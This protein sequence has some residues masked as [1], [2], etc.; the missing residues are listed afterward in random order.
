M[1]SVSSAA[2]ERLPAR[3]PTPPKDTTTAVNEAL[4]FLE[5]DYALEKPLSDVPRDG[6]PAVDTTPTQTPPSSLQTGSGKKGVKK[7]EFSPW[8]VAVGLSPK[9]N[10]GSSP[11]FR[12]IHSNRDVRPPK[13]ILKSTLGGPPLTPDEN[14]SP[15]PG[16]FSLDEPGGFLKMLESVMQHLANPSPALRLDGYRTLNGALKTYDNLPEAK[17]IR[18]RMGMLQQHI[19]R[20]LSA[21]GKAGSTMDTNLTTQ[22]LRLAVALLSPQLSPALTDDFKT[23]LVD[24]SIE[25]L[26][27]EKPVKAVA[28]LYMYL[29][30][31]QKWGAHI[32]TTPKAEKL[33]N[34]LITIQEKISG[35]SVVGLRLVIYQKL[36]DQAPSVML[37][38]IGGWLKD[39]FNGLLSSIEEVR[40]RAI[41]CG[42]Q[43]G[44]I[45]GT[46]SLATK[47]L[48]ELLNT[49]TD[50]EGATYGDYLM[51]RMTE[52]ITKKEDGP[53]VGQI[54]GVVVLF[55]RSK[56]RTLTGWGMLKPWLLIIQK[57]LNSSDIQTKFQAF[58]A[59][60][61]LV[62]VVEPDTTKAKSMEGMIPMLK[63]PFIA[64]FDKKGRDKHSKDA[65]E[66]ALFG[67]CN[68]L[69][70]ALRPS[71]SFEDLDLCWDEYVVPIISKLLKSGGRD[72]MLGCRILKALFNSKTT[73]WNPNAANENS[74]MRPEDLPML[75]RQWIRSRTQKIISL[76]EPYLS[77]ILR[78]PVEDCVKQSP[79]L[80][81]LTAI[82]EAGRQEVRASVEFKDALAS[83]VNLFG[84]L[85]S[86]ASQ[87]ALE[88]ASQTWIL[89]YGDLVLSAID[90]FGPLHF[91][92]DFL[93]RNKSEAFEVAPTPSSRSSK[94]HEALESPAAY[95]LSLFYRPPPSLV[96]DESY[97]DTAHKLIQ[98]V[99][100]SKSSRKTRLDLLRHISHRTRLDS[101][102]QSAPAIVAANVWARIAEQ[103]ELTFTD[104]T[105]TDTDQGS[106]RLGPCIRDAV[107]VLMAGFQYAEV[108]EQAPLDAGLALYSTLLK[109]LKQ[110]A[111]TGAVVLG[112]VEP[113]AQELC[114]SQA[115][116]PSRS[117]TR[118]TI[119][120]LRGCEWPR[121]RQQ[122]DEGRKALWGSTLP[123]PKH[124]IFD[125]F[126]HL[127]QLNVA[128]LSKAYN[129]IGE[130]LE[131]CTPLIEAN[132]T[133]VESCPASLLAIA[134]RRMQD[135]LVLWVQ[136][137][138]RLLATK[139]KA[140]QDLA[141]Q[142]S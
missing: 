25:V 118:Y 40:K 64:A 87:T 60:N 73:V 39:V 52:S 5:V 142:V 50:Y 117:L 76:I 33:V 74:R 102:A 1:V 116:I 30:G 32:I 12:R 141:A 89:R 38:S 58:V 133:F 140:E 123:A 98:A 96:V 72:S 68:L 110:A 48:L 106:Q 29:L 114:R 86:S 9:K 90:E 42:L 97:F 101:T 54:W 70:Y 26:S 55:F 47:A 22:A 91:T 75:N 130:C 108:P 65:R 63:V 84:R 20:D 4:E 28:N 15:A 11:V 19:R 57:C 62:F 134:L 104:D 103:T 37:S 24:R 78:L 46:N 100:A 56:K 128:A 31:Y 45:L 6:V 125:P 99:A 109:T 136:D 94:H 129:N 53:S 36:L 139:G 120:I 127:Y 121:N 82:V 71:Q 92:E 43:A 51:V 115:S 79:W 95:L 67:Y 3:P 27:Q 2:F 113:V 44:I 137:E 124:A 14:G 17:A 7:V 138:H 49:S 23:M 77:A 66:I 18:E 107:T 59:W 122:M 41:E 16:Y 83:L 34:S 111:G 85:W 69:H 119:G 88:E 80:E 112:L 10:D 61:R 13:S 132:I 8:T 21:S 126:D 105:L 131:Y 81:L 93:T 35:N 135:G